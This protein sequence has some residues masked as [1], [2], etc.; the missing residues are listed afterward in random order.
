MTILKKGDIVVVVGSTVTKDGITSRHKALAK[1]VAVGRYDAFAKELNSTGTLSSNTFKISKKR[2]V[3]VNDS[4]VEPTHDI[5]CPR[6]GDLVL[7]YQTSYSSNT[8]VKTGILIE[9]IDRPGRHKQARIL[10]GAKSDIVTFD[11][12]LILEH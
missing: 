10:Q 8:E 2:C 1:L 3:K 5:T 11:S 12:L 4:H 7:S 6:L 9:I